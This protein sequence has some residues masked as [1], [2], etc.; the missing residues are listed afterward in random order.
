MKLVGENSKDWYSNGLRFECQRCGRC[1]TNRGPYSFVFLSEADVSSLADNLGLARAEFLARH[2]AQHEG[3]TTLRTD[4][5]RC[6]FQADDGSCGVY[7]ARP[8][9]CRSWP[10]WRENLVRETWERDV[11]PLC[12][13]VG[14]GPLR[15][16]QEIEVIAQ[17]DERWYAD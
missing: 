14:T 8:H 7:S 6:E 10:F 17:R 2:T 4:L 9:Q 5:A 16:A 11:V 3:R 12:P 13:G 1:C 15:S